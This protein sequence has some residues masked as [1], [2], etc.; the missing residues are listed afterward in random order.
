VLPGGLIK[1]AWAGAQLAA[2]L[3]S[4]SSREL[5]HTDLVKAAQT[6][7]LSFAAIDA[8]LLY[9]APSHSLCIIS[10]YR[11]SATSHLPVIKGDL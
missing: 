1:E 7:V 5:T 8:R 2:M 11:Q 9:A 6:Q 3:R 10:G 4:G